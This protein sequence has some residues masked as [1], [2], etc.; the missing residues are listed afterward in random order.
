MKNRL[1][2]LRRN[3]ARAECEAF[4]SLSGPANQYLTGF[5]GST[6]AV[7]VTEDAAWFL[8]DFRYTEQAGQE[9]TTFTVEECANG[10]PRE[11]GKRLKAL[12]T[13]T[14]AFDPT[15]TS[16]AERD[17]I[18]SAFECTCNPAADIVS[19]LRRVKDADEIARIRAA[20]RLADG[21]LA[22]VLADLHEGITERDLAARL[23]YEFKKRGASGA[24]FDTIALFG[25]RT[26]LV[27]GAPGDRPLAS[28][29]AVLVDLG[30]RLRGYCSDLTRTY[31][32]GR[33]PAAW[34]QDVYDLTQTAQQLALEAVRPGV[35]CREIDA[36]ARDFISEGGHGEHFGHGLGH[37][38]GIEVHEAPRLHRTSDAILEEGMV[39]TIEPGIY[40]PHRGGVRIEDLV[41][42]TADGCEVLSGAPKELKVITA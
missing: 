24:A 6:S 32:F 7:L 14:V 27:H 3:M 5:T 4:V 19:S 29:D 13:T 34:F 21:V 11:L 23:E 38:V 8:C 31:A 33:I 41:V 15:V 10:L 9:V 2:A 20:V 35:S 40:L 36:I 16:V 18:E 30:C 1:K 37:G 22:D 25:A 42:V 26:S 28:G 17:Q 39:V 12:D